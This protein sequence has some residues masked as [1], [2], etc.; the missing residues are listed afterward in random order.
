VKA[1]KRKTKRALTRRDLEMYQAVARK[2]GEMY[3]AVA[4]KLRAD[5]ERGRRMCR[6]CWS[7]NG[8][9]P[10]WCKKEV[11]DALNLYRR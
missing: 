1:K 8:H 2:L 9:H 6:V 11:R 7:T 3:P 5:N 10:E 4:R